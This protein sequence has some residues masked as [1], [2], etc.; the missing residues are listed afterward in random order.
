MAYCFIFATSWEPIFLCVLIFQGVI[1]FELIFLSRLF[2]LSY[3]FSLLT[4]C[5]RIGT[6]D[7]SCVSGLV[8]VFRVSCIIVTSVQVKRANMDH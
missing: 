5:I 7:Y 6:F 8:Q 3:L 1:Y 2:I 4:F